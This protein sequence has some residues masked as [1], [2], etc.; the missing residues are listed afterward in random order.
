MAFPIC[1]FPPCLSAQG[2]LD[3]PGTFLPVPPG[4]TRDP[5]VRDMA[6]N[7]Y[8]AAISFQRYSHEDELTHICEFQPLSGN[9]LSSEG[10][11]IFEAAKDASISTPTGERSLF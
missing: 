10:Q 2:R 3:D 6:H 11:F 7:P 9:D 4:S 1:C 8:R 5:L